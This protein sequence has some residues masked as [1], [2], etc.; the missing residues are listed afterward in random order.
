MFDVYFSCHRHIDELTTHFISVGDFPY[1]V[2]EYT[3]ITTFSSFRDVEI[4]Y[5]I[6][7]FRRMYFKDLVHVKNKSKKSTHTAEIIG[8]DSD[9][10][11][12]SKFS[13]KS[14][15]SKQVSRRG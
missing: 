5:G 6:K 13:M 4:L 2:P 3:S 15:R 9:D 10:T 7:N 11:E 12:S 14:L 1:M 8:T